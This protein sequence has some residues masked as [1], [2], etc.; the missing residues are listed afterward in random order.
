METT[1]KKVADDDDDDVI[2]D[3]VIS[4]DRRI[5]PSQFDGLIYIEL[6]TSYNRCYNRSRSAV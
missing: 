5:I 3:D 1:L 4:V 2:D 6:S